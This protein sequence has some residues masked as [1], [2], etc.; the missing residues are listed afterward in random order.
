MVRNPLLLEW[1]DLVGSDVEAAIDG[2]RIARDHLAAESA[3]ERD[4]ERAFSCGRRAD[5]R[6]ERRTCQDQ[7][8][9]ATA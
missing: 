3:R 7:M 9:R 6:D 8:R 5:D 4:R 2:R 1:R